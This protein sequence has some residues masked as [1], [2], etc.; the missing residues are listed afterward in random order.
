MEEILAKSIR[1]AKL[2]KR[3]RNERAW[4]QSQ[5]AEIAGVNLRTIQR[6]EKDGVASFETLMGIASAFDIDVRELNQPATGNQRKNSQRSVYLL[7]RIPTGKHLTNVISEADQFQLE[8]DEAS[9]PRSIGAM[10][11]ILELLKGDVVRLYDASPIERIQV[12][13][14]LTQEIKGLENY[15]FYLFG[16]KRVIPHID[17]KGETEIT[18][19]T[20]FMS[21]SQSPKI[22]KDKK[23][24][25][26]VPAVLTEVVR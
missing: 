4:T 6:V 7:P 26:M 16:I 19:C 1:R 2:I 23:S 14:E 12:E 13:A 24:N 8:H 17:S 20:L 15:G 22:I 18:M 3:E 21:H 25:M 5:L 10:K 11:G 9:D